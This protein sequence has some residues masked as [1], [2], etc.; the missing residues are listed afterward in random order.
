MGTAGRGK[1]RGL[2]TVAAAVATL[3]TAA[4]ACSSSS[5]STAPTIHFHLCKDNAGAIDANV[6]ACNKSAN[7]AYK[8]EYDLLPPG[9]DDQRQQLVRRLAAK[10]K[11]LDILGMD[12]VWA[13]EFASAGWVR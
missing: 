7:G 10:D 6:A 5:A 9:A 12:V 13:P 1:F 8:L 4:G 2:V 11:S 3:S